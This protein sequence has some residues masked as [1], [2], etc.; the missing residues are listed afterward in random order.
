MD[1]WM[2]GQADGWNLQHWH[3]RRKST[4]IW[5]FAFPPRTVETGRSRR[6]HGEVGGWVQHGGEGVLPDLSFP[7]FPKAFTTARPE[8]GESGDRKEGQPR[9][10]GLTKQLAF[11]GW[12]RGSLPGQH[13]QRH[14][15][16]LK[17]R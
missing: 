14:R 2:D 9:S 3:L 11:P 17:S 13:V 16:E 15:G 5:V 7:T 10:P 6:S 1:G 8:E 12:G 4:F